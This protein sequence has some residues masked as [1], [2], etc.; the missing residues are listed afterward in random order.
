[1]NLFYNLFNSYY[2]TIFL[3]YTCN[4]DMERCQLD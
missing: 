4:M 2:F 1:M 3:A